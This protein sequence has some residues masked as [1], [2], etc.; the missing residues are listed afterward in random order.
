MR[1]SG[2]K[3]LDLGT[4][5]L[6]VWLSLLAYSIFLRFIP[7]LTFSAVPA[8]HHPARLDHLHVVLVAGVVRDEL[9]G[10]VSSLLVPESKDADLS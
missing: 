1:I 3:K 8:R 9:V 2:L 7:T 10:S 6:L 4:Y 5:P